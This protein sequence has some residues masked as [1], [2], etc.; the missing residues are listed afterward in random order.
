MSKWL[1][2]WIVLGAI[3]GSGLA[4]GLTRNNLSLSAVEP[5]T[6][7]AVIPES[8]ASVVSRQPLSLNFVGDLML[9]RS[10]YLKTKASG[11]DYP[12]RKIGDLFDNADLVI[13]NLEG[14]VTERG[15]HAVPSGSLLFKFEPTVT[16]GLKSAG[17]DILSLANNHTYNQGATGFADSLTNLQAAGISP[18]GNPRQI[19]DDD[20]LI[21]EVEGWKLAFIGWNTIEVTD[22]HETEL[23]ALIRAIK[24]T[25]DRV[26]IMPHWG[27]EYKPQTK[28]QIASAH[29]LVDAGA[30]II[31]GG[32]AHT[33]QGVEVYNNCPIF[34][35]LGNFIFDQYWSDPTEQGLMVKLTLSDDAT[36]AQVVPID[37][38]QSQPREASG[39]I[40]GAILAR[41]IDASDSLPTAMKDELQLN[42]RLTVP[43][44]VLNQ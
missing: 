21:R 42:A 1:V 4:F 10:V 39:A 8:T 22:D 5:T 25:V 44:T 30:D 40:S 20:I 41:L 43:T 6:T 9:D 14:P 27:G 29:A 36:V 28:S 19:S 7:M 33:V 24:P 13:G 23:I 34:Y 18:I 32:H 38:R 31:I 2:F 37:L 15:N 17:F 3:A 26:I 35:S 12:Y 16:N 11:S